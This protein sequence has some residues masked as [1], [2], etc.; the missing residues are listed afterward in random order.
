MTSNEKYLER[1]FD[2]KAL[3]VEH[4]KMMSER[5]EQRLLEK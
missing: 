2:K 5:R 3:E 1:V 4:A